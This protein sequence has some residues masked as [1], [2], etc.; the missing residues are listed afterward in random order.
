MTIT[1]TPTV[2]TVNVPARVRLDIS[3]SAGETSTTVTRINP[4]GTV[5]PVRTSDGN[6]LT[7]SG[8]TGLL[9]DYEMPYG[10]AVSYSSQESPAT[11]SA[12]V[13]VDVL[14]PWLIHPGV[15]AL[16]MPIS[17]RPGTLQDEMFPLTRGVFQVLGRANPVVFTDGVRHGSQSQIVVTTQSLSEMGSLKALLSDGSVLLLNIPA[18]M[19]TG[20]DTAYVAVGDLKVSRWTD[21]AIDENRDFVLPF[22]VVDRPSGGTQSQRTYADV[23][24]RFASYSAV[25][26]AYPSYT[27]LLAGP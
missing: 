20:F 11:T 14:V 7:L 12:Q 6:P 19:Q 16:S 8:S 13:T 18:G 2:D 23:L 1:V 15:P 5:V 10:A 25:L 21:I 9:Y 4:D 24:A 17:F 27:A 22:M 26:A 3:A